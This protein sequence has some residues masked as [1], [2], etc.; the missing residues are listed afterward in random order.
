MLS[1]ASQYAIRAIL[2]LAQNSSSSHKISAL[3]I[4]NELETPKPF[5]SKLLRQLALNNLVS[6]TKGPHGGFFLSELNKEKRLWD[7]VV[8]I[9]G[10][11]K[12]SEC[13]LGLPQCSSK[14]PCPFHNIVV[15]FRESLASSFKQ[16]NI[17]ELIEAME[18]DKTL[19]SLKGLDI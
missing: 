19:I 8:C 11:N 1:H 14:N 10:G 13:F 17:Q 2:Y 16:K 4:A 12:F 7:V 9:D 5:L 6:S 18:I 15:P 3:M